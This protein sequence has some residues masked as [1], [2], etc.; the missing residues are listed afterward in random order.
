[1]R[2]DGVMTR[3][4]VLVHIGLMKTGTSYLQSLLRA[5]TEE[6]ARQGLVMVPDTQPRSRELARA[7][8]GALDEEADLPR[9]RTAVERL[10]TELEAAGD[11][12]VLISDETLAVAT[13]AQVSRLGA[14]LG[15]REAHVVVTARDPARILPSAWQ[16]TV[17]GG[18]QDSFEEYLHRVTQGKG[19]GFRR[20]YDLVHVLERWAGLAPPERTHVVTLPPPGAAPTVLRDRF[21][22]VLGVDGGSLR[23]GAT[24]TN[25]SLGVAQ[26]ELMRRLNGRLSPLTFRR[27]LHGPVVKRGF[28]IAVLAAQGGQRL[29]VPEGLRPWC[30]EQGQRTRAWIEDRGC[31]VVGDLDDLLPRYA[32]FGPAPTASETEVAGAAEAALASLLDARAEE[33]AQQRRRGR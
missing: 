25:E 14:A 26:A 10:G 24:R 17:K 12:R 7:L 19:S 29:M 30:E 8:R 11:H 28:A 15:D 21:C 32:S 4:P 1:M 18:S 20:T 2:L 31:R 3:G 23:Q 9:A 5:S 22:E 33:L 13:P 16:Q 27:D 6:L